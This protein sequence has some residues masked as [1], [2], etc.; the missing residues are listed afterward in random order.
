MQR[1][2]T[3][4]NCCTRT[5]RF[6]NIDGYFVFRVALNS[7]LGKKHVCDG[8]LWM[9]YERPPSRNEDTDKE[10]QSKK[11]LKNIN[12]ITSGGHQDEMNRQVQHRTCTYGIKYPDHREW[13]GKNI[14]TNSWRSNGT[15][16]VTKT[17]DTSA[18]TTLS[19]FLNG[20]QVMSPRGFASCR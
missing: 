20:P 18:L 12:V 10:L 1:Y 5:C 19:S 7:S 6:E 11:Q 17:H 9:A 14:T 8:F 13:W 2:L 4:Y 15:S 16:G 3:Y